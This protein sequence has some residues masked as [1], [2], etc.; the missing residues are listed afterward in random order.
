M[1]EEVKVRLPQ[2]LG[3]QDVILQNAASEATMQRMLEVFE[4]FSG[5]K[6]DPVKKQTEKQNTQAQQQN[7]DAVKKA[8][9]QIEDFYNELNKS[10][11]SLT[12]FGNAAKDHALN[13]TAATQDLAGNIMQGG[14]SFG[15]LSGILD[16]V[17]STTAGAFDGLASTIPVVGDGLGKLGG[18]A[19]MA[20]AAVAGFALAQFDN[21]A[22]SFDQTAEAGAT[23][24]GQLMQLKDTATAS[25]MSLT[26]FTNVIRRTSP[27]LAA[28]GGTV[29]SGARIL[30]EVVSNVSAR[31]R[32]SLILAGI[33]EEQLGDM[34]A[35]FLAQQ[36]YAGRL[37]LLSTEQA[38]QG[39]VEFAKNLSTLSALTGEDIDRIKQ[40]QEQMRVQSE[41][42]STLQRFGG[43]V[44]GFTQ[45]AANFRNIA[46]RMGPEFESVFQEALAFGQVSTRS[47]NIVIAANQ[48]AGKLVVD[49]AQRI[50]QGMDPKEAMQLFENRLRE[51]APGIISGV[52]NN[53]Q[54]GQLALLGVQSDLVTTTANVNG[55]LA[56]FLRAFTDAGSSF[57]KYMSTADAERKKIESGGDDL[58]NIVATFRERMNAAVRAIEEEVINKGLKIGAAAIDTA[59]DSVEKAVKDLN[60]QFG[61]LTTNTGTLN[62]ALQQ[63]N[64]NGQQSIIE[65]TVRDTAS[66][67]IPG[68]APGS[69]SVEKLIVKV[70]QGETLTGEDIDNLMNE[71]R[72][73]YSA[74]REAQSQGGLFNY[75]ETSLAGK[76]TQGITSSLSDS[77]GLD[78]LAVG[79]DIE[80]QQKIVAKLKELKRQ[81]ELSTRLAPIQVADQI[82]DITLKIQDLQQV[83]QGRSLTRKEESAMVDLEQKL[84]SATQKYAELTGRSLQI[85]DI[86]FAPFQSRT[87]SI[88]T[89]QI[90]S[91]LSS[92]IQRLEQ[93][94]GTT[95]SQIQQ[96]QQGGVQANEQ[97]DYKNLT[98]ELRAQTQKL[99]EMVT[100]LKAVRTNS[101]KLMQNTY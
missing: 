33:N 3:G 100:E 92:E 101:H 75:I 89:S 49:M 54:M 80:S 98:A 63:I 79:E 55:G 76:L 17:A 10:N 88:D 46:S 78:K 42:A 81:E 47:N 48:E 2:E 94:Q 43:T 28:I 61:A 70:D 83:Q 99:Q 4:K 15:M 6:S 56:E 11:T 90:Q 34:T 93:L 68:V 27:Q 87:I 44:E 22:Q 82:G 40:Q 35:E 1:A 12:K 18:A 96:I 91:A 95:N 24:G 67:Y 39:A 36:R 77:L 32:R 72:R 23:F 59:F 14:S 26:Q 41:Y 7:T 97:Q 5:Q 29:S 64:G 74:T 85:P 57:E 73:Q 19:V 84:E 20:G 66:E 71:Y 53:A 37:S 65:Q 50:R 45:N 51:S 52:Q 31:D 21:I 13:L 58:G 38:S 69:R 30:G 8:N 25:R 9:E 60:E 16:T 62:Q 86:N